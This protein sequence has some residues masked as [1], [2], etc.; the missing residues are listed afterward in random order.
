MK[1][2][3]FISAFKKPIACEMFIVA[4]EIFILIG[5]IELVRTIFYH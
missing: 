5:L 4:Q 1:I 2:S 3:F